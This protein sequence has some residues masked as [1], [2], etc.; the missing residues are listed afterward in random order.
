VQVPQLAQIFLAPKV[1]VLQP[2][3]LLVPWVQGTK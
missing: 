1:L 2:T 3:E